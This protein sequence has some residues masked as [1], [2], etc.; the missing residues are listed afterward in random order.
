MEKIS[1]SSKNLSSVG[2]DP[3][4]LTL[5]VTFRSG[6]TYRYSGVSQAVYQ[7]LLNAPSHG[8]FFTQNIK[9]KYSFVR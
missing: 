7:E 8:K 9:G 1:I 4:N 2:Y 5:E 3:T 6:G